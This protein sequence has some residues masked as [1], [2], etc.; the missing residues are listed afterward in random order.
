MLYTAN[1]ILYCPTYPWLRIKQANDFPLQ[2]S[3]LYMTSTLPLATHASTSP[4]WA[5]LYS[6]P[7]TRQSPASGLQGK[8]LKSKPMFV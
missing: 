2:V 1:I 7:D 6:G 8:P 4:F 5:S 3:R